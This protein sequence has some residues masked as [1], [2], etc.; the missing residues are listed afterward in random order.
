M[1]VGVQISVL[2]TSINSLGAISRHIPRS[3]TTGSYDNSVSIFEELAHCILLQLCHFLFSSAKHHRVPISP[4]PCQ[5][6]FSVLDLKLAILVCVR[7][8][9]I[10]VL[11]C[12]SLMISDIVH[13]SCAN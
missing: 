13:L 2:V 9:H 3:E 11:V 1:K 12:I 7:W 8:C 10:M 6:L 5:L 4:H